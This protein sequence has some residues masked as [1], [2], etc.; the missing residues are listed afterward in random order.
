MAQYTA[1]RRR[2]EGR[3]V[4]GV[5]AVSATRCGRLTLGLGQD[6][7]HLRFDHLA[8]GWQVPASVGQ[9]DEDALG[10]WLPSA[11]TKPCTHPKLKRPRLLV[12]PLRHEPF[13]WVFL[14]LGQVIRRQR[15]QLVDEEV[16]RGE[17]KVRRED[18]G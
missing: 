4:G 7:E 17:D 9:G 2:I 14:H 3:S 12:H 5:A 10:A 13:L 18:W 16:Q 1:S 6:L 11:R 8:I 15:Q